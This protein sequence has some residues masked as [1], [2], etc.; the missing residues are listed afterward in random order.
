MK[1]QEQ[2]PKPGQVIQHN[3]HLADLPAL[4][5]RMIQHDTSLELASSGYTLSE[6]AEGMRFLLD[7]HKELTERKGQGKPGGLG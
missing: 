3:N 7:K 6:A 1:K 2:K 4:S 5:F